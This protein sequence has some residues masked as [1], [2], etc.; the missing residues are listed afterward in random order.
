MPV[1]HLGRNM[2]HAHG[3]QGAFET[4]VAHDGAHDHIVLEPAPFLIHAGTYGDDLVTRETGAAFIDGDEAIAVAVESESCS[5]LEFDHPLR[6]SLGM[7]G[8]AV[9]I[10]VDA[11]RPIVDDGHVGPQG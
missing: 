1:A 10:D 7:L 3:S 8:P 11:V 9:G 6:E 2:L 4:E 5:S